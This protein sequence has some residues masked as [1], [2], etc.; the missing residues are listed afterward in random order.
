MVRDLREFISLLE[1]KGELARVREELD[2]RFEISAFLRLLD[3]RDGPA[4][5]FERVRG[6]TIPVAADLYR[7]P[8]RM[9]LA[10]GAEEKKVIEELERRKRNLIP[11]REI[12]KEEA[13]VKE[14]VVKG[15]AVDIP[16]IIPV[17]T[18]HSRDAG[19]YITQGVVILKDPDTHAQTL[20]V[21]RIQVKGRNKLGIFLS[22][23]G[24][25][26]EFMRKHEE[27]GMHTDVAIALG[28]EP[29]L[30]F[31]AISAFPGDKMSLAGALKEEP[32]EVVR[33]ETV[34]LKVPAQAMFV[35]EGRIP[36]GV[37]EVEGPFG[38]SSGFYCTYHNPVVEVTALTF[39]KDPI[40]SVSHP[41]SI[42]ADRLLETL[43]LPEMRE[44][45]KKLIPELRDVRIVFPAS[46]VIIS[47][48]KRH[49]WDGRK[50][51]L[52]ALAHFPFKY[53]IAVDDD[54][55]IWDNRDLASAFYGRFQPSRGLIHLED[56]W[57]ELDPSAREEQR[58]GGKVGF[59]ATC[60][61]DQRE[62]LEKADV[63]VEAKEKAEE[64]L[65]KL[66]L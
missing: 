50:A 45:M 49:S 8:R 28:P 51:I 57:V 42:E 40:Y 61:L 54:V 16:G 56:L 15:E 2:P 58:V 7:T 66:R 35:I 39:R 64:V 26:H 36:P 19:P 44:V 48:R 23:F 27:R 18:Y 46:L 55:D 60:P 52:T 3:G 21:H 25:A 53:A 24:K 32:I 9:A 10:L 1:E 4:V 41:Y 12:P 14:K 65:R 63:P 17:L 59:D 31:A 62:L 13:P 20:G 30:L 11:P 5:L 6:Y 33:G 38:E 43:Y 37:R 22:P 47:M 34:D 29:P